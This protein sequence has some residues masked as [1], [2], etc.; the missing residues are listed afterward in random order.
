VDVAGWLRD[1]GL[2]RYEA[3]FRKNDVSAE[4]LRDLT[5]E[6]LEGLGVVTIGHRRRLLVAIAE[7]RENAAPLQTLRI[8]AHRATSA[9]ERRQITVLFCDIVGSTPLSIGLDPEELR[10][11]LTT[12]QA[13]VGAVVAGEHG[14]IARFVGDGV[15]A[16]FGWPNPDE[17]HAESAVRAGLAIIDAISAQRLSVRIGIA[18]G[19]V[20]TGDLVGVGAAQTMTAVGETPNLAARLQA[21]AQPDTVVVSEATQTQLG[22]LFE[23]EDLG[24]H[25]LKGFDTPVRPWRALGKT[26]AVSRSEVVYANAFTPLVGRD[27]E[28]GLL[29][30]RWHEA[31]AGEGLVVLLS[32]EAGIG[33][34]RLLAALEERLTGEPH[35]SQ[36]YFCSPHHQSSPL[37]PLIARLEREA[38]FIRGDTGEDRLIK[39]EAALGPTA[40]PEDVVLLAASLSIPTNERY[41]ILELSPQQRKMRTFTALLN[42]LAGLARKEPVLLLFEDAHWSE[43]R[44]NC[45]TP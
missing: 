5:A 13:N 45:W 6:D 29:L 32:G 2:E 34:S 28:L 40:P 44:S 27:E 37:Y 41:P 20:V 42:R 15:L 30:R 36:H 35:V 9:A 14:Y 3:A 43:A 26:V 39:L 33:K 12:Y 11:I 4:V 8:D 17:A 21:L 38:G 10:E 1:L 18:T 23:L 7:L 19:L 16:Y 25:T 31:K 24:L 22:H